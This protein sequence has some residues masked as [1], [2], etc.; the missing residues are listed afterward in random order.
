MTNP[1]RQPLK[2][3]GNTPNDLKRVLQVLSR[4]DEGSA[5]IA[6]VA[7]RLGPLLDAGLPIA[8]G[9]P[10][11]LRFTAHIPKVLRIVL[12]GSA[13]TAALWFTRQGLRQVPSVEPAAVLSPAIAVPSPTDIVAAR[14]SPVADAPRAEVPLPAAGLSA[15]G[16]AVRVQCETPRDSAPLKASAR[17]ERRRKAPA[18]VSSGI[19]YALVASA[20][21]AATAPAA[22]AD[23]PSPSPPS[24]GTSASLDSE[25]AQIPPP[26]RAPSEA[27]LLVEARSKLGAFPAEALAVLDQHAQR[28]ATGML[29]P[30][31]EV[32]AIEAL[33]A[34]G[35][36]AEA[37]QRTQAFRQKY[38]DSL[39]LRRLDRQGLTAH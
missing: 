10:L 16:D 5:R 9:R 30:E 7:E 4:Q 20:P 23:A 32:M 18:Q 33:R 19:D 15:A 22:T 8:A 17:R 35:R 21:V 28:F 25:P 6:R 36:M 37:D 24:P 2:G 26:P 38:P 13:V 11:L 27:A 14:S 34:L 39:H 12:A 29:A 31:R 1:P 3:D